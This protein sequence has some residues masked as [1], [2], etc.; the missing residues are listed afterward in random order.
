MAA[1]VRVATPPAQPPLGPWVSCVFLHAQRKKIQ[2][3][4]TSVKGKRINYAFQRG[5]GAEGA[6]GAPGERK[7]QSA[8]PEKMKWH[9]TFDN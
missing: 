8:E 9:H 1:I 6:A 7:E 4:K 2:N 5:R 3:P